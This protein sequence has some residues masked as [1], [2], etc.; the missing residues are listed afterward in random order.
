M[1]NF[2]TRAQESQGEAQ[3]EPAIRPFYPRFLYG[4]THYSLSTITWMD[5]HTPLLHGL[6]AT[7][8]AAI[9][10]RTSISALKTILSPAFDKGGFT[11]I[12]PSSSI[13]EFINKF[14]GQI[15]ALLS[16][17]TLFIVSWQLGCPFPF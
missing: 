4:L 17:R 11:F 5:V 1:F 15:I 6:S 12:V 13:C 3:K 14:T 8:H 2:S 16:P 9:P 10:T 7:L